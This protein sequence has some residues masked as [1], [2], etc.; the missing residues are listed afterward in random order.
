MGR[1]RTG[2]QV[3][4]WTLQEQLGEGGNA[5]V[6]LANDGRSEVAL[7]VLKNR[8][9]KSEPYERF[10]REVLALRQIGEHP[11][12]LPLLEGYLPEHLTNTEHAWLAMPVAEPLR[13]A[14]VGSALSQ[15]VR[16]VSTIASTLADLQARFG[17]HHR[18]IKPSNLYV[19]NAEPAV[20]DFGLV[21][22]PSPSDLTDD[23]RPV[24]PTHFIPY[25]MLNDPSRAQAGPVDVYSLAK[26]L[27]VLC[28]DQ[29]WPPPGPQPASD[30]RLALDVLRP[31]RHASRLDG[32]IERATR[33]SPEE[34]PTMREFADDLKSWLQL[35][36][37]PEA[38]P[39]IATRLHEL[40]KLA[41]PR[42][43]EEARQ[44]DLQVAAREATRRLEELLEPLHA[45]MKAGF[46][47]VEL[48]VNDKTGRSLTRPPETM[49]RPKI[50]GEDSRS[51]IIRGDR[52][53][54][55]LVLARW[56]GVTEDGLLRAQ[57]ACYIG[58]LG[59]MGSIDTWRSRQ[60][61][62]PVRSVAAEAALQELVAEVQKRMDGWLEVL[63]DAWRPA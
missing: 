44:K 26:T 48:N 46:P 61:A 58:R 55:S 47:G 63:L 14:M 7:K 17:I 10:R 27:W 35:P 3:G 36:E 51:T 5:E 52:S 56:V 4:R 60:I 21:D 49:G 9:T 11:N 53:S 29:H 19:L 25:E 2:L 62:V 42:L 57:A 18:D 6:W 37:S 28:A 38:M 43:T 30:R 39:D 15:I 41:S 1:F 24:G 45:E 32:L 23:R 54:A 33:H 31:H 50:A 20:G 34:R 40:R 16:S 22:L 12:V 59:V 8:N 13:A